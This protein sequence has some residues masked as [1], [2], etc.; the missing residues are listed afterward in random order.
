MRKGQMYTG[1]VIDVRFPNKGIVEVNKREPDD[2][3]ADGN[4][5]YI[6]RKSF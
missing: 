5:G 2:N 6:Y 3:D 4:L 1:N